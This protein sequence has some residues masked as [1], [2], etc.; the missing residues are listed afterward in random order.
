MG[1]QKS[2]KRFLV[3]GVGS[4]YFLTYGYD[5]SKA[6]PSAYGAG[7]LQVDIGQPT[8]PAQPGLTG[9]LMIWAHDLRLYHHA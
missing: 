5:L 3:W 4:V 1:L 9:F 8:P 7:R 2:Q 6:E